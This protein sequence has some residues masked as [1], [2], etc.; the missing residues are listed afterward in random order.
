MKTTIFFL[1]CNFTVACL[2]QQ[3]QQS[4]HQIKK[5]DNGLYF[6]YYDTTKEKK[7]VTKS[8]IV[9]FRD[10]IVLIEMPISND[11]AEAKQLSDHTTEG[12]QVLQ[13][14]KG[15]FPAKP[16]KYVL[17]THWHPHSISSVTPFISRKITLVTTSANF[18]R[19]REC[20]DSTTFVQYSKYIRY[21]DT[22]SIIIQD[23]TNIIVAYHIENRNNPH[24]PTKDFLYFYLPRYNALHISCMYYRYDNKFVAGKELIYGRNEDLSRFI[25]SKQFRPD[26]LIRTRAD[27]EE[28]NG[29][30]P[31]T[32][33]QHIMETGITMTTIRDHFL[34]M[35]TTL[36]NTKTDSIVRAALVNAVPLSTFSTVINEAL[37]KNDLPQALSFAKIQALLNPSDAAS[38]D[39]YGKI[40]YFLGE[41]ELAKVYEAQSK[42]INPHYAPS[43]Q[44]VWEKEWQTYQAM[45]KK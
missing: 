14:L 45:W 32:R 16:L 39:T 22:D 13:S 43:G 5:I 18:E 4:F 15:Y 41:K 36:L 3:Q 44:T 23:K 28:T 11:G 8:T 31:Y 19:I 40:Y 1:L 24:L 9:E 30:I 21:A 20:I 17:S 12:E 7:L 10:F 26:H 29:M 27:Q 6:M 25:V 33:L 37:K 34:N 35:S 2:A 42:K 38:W